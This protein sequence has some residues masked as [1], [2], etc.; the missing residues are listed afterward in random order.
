MELEDTTPK[1]TVIDQISTKKSFMEL[2]DSM[3]AVHNRLDELNEITKVRW[4]NIDTV[5]NLFKWGIILICLGILIII[6]FVYRIMMVY[7]A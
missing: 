3:D 5:V 1:N 7:K 4:N 6:T 2:S